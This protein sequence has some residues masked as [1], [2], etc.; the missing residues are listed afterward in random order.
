MD[1]IEDLIGFGLGIRYEDIPSE[2]LERTRLAVLDTLGTMIAGIKG[3]GVPELDALV[4]TWGG[5][6]QSAL[7]TTGRRAPMHTAALINAVAARAWDLDDVHEQ[8]T[9]HV[10]ASLVPALLS[11]AQARPVVSGA[12]ALAAAAVGAEV[13]CRLSSAPRA[14]FSK[15]GS[16]MTYQCAQ[17]AVAL[18]AARL[19]GLS[20][21]QTRHAL[22][23]AHARLSGNQQ[24]F[25]AG[26]M[27]VRL[28]Q[29]VSAESGVVSALMAES[30]LTGSSEI[31][32]GKF[33]YFPVYHHGL[34]ERGDLVDGLGTSW[35]V[36][37]V[38]I[39]PA[40]PCCKYTHAP[41]AAALEVRKLLDTDPGNIS[42]VEV[43]VTNREVHDLVCLSRE[44]KWNPRTLADAQFS[45]PFTIAH[46]MVHGRVDLQSFQPS[47]RTDPAVRDFMPRIEI[48]TAFNSQ[49]ES[50]G[51]FP[52]PGIVTARTADGREIR[53]EVTY[54][55]GHPRN[56][57]SFDDV[58]EKFRA[59]AALGLPGAGGLD[60]IVDATASL[61]TLPDVSCL[62]DLCVRSAGRPVSE[63]QQ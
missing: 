31:L 42:A 56:P 37:E 59:C 16:S 20:R 55:K 33:G 2:V 21:D 62:M 49:G 57:M 18:M 47:G 52:M 17:Y 32:E 30:G 8:N 29:G 60:E 58:A 38:S 54:V 40:S 19:F 41:I 7:I 28:M 22:G 14:S 45:L 26:A 53:R 61:E 5:A 10:F 24:G 51:T 13:V 50:R 15:T 6:G 25:L 39:K 23:I 9:C 44:R 27:T 3:E 46:A 11:I 4:Q 43:N 36:P 48:H 63:L 1:A 34:Y 35:K 12:A